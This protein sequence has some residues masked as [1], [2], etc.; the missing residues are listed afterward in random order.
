[1][2]SEYTCVDG[3]VRYEERIVIGD[4]GVLREQL[5]KDAHDSYIEGHA[6][7]QNSYKKPYFYCSP[8]K[9][10]VKKIVAQYDICKQAKIA[11]VVYPDLL[12]AL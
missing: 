1:M 6:G 8:M 9:K 4:K 11:R 12:H 7:I 5:V 2:W 3:I 10:L